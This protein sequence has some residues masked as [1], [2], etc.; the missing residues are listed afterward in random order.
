MNTREHHKGISN[1]TGKL[2]MLRNLKEHPMHLHK[3]RLL[4]TTLS[5]EM[6]FANVGIQ[7]G[8]TMWV[9]IEFNQRQIMNLDFIFFASIVEVRDTED[10]QVLAAKAIAAVAR[11]FPKKRIISFRPPAKRTLDGYPFGTS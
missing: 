9:Y 7:C 10:F 1:T 3:R 6:F 4:N 2:V 5:H 8:Y 11:I